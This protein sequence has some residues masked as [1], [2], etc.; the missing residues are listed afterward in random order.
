MIP[1][2]DALDAELPQTQ[3]RA[4]D[5]PACRP[6][7]EAIVRGEAA[8]NQCA[9][10][11]ERVLAA[12]ARLTGQPALPLREPERPLRLARIREAECI[13][14]TLCIQACPVDAIVGS[15]KRMHTVIAAEC[16]GCEL[17]LP[18]CPVDCIELLPMPQPAPEQRVN[19]A[20][21][22]RH[23]FLAREQRL[24][25]EVLRRTERLATRRREHALAASASDPVTTTPDG[26]TVD[27]R[28]ILQQAIARARAQRSKT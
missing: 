22:W 20:E 15:A 5:Y 23:R 6:Y 21:Q 19:L 12:L 28:A 1:L 9:P 26:Q 14:C 16:N 11:G 13:G 10:G 25:R 18:P 24:A 3:C 17:C 4:C 2:V 7:A 8:I 27:K